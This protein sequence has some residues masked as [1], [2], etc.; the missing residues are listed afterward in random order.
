MR[1]IIPTTGWS[2]T[3]TCWASPSPRPASCCSSFSCVA[4]AAPA[5][6]GAIDLVP[7]GGLAAALVLGLVWLVADDAATPALPE[8]E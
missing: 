8:R 3:S 1:A 2:L 5:A 7:L 6:F 4:P